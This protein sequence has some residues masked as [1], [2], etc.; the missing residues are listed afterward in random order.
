[1]DVR[2]TTIRVV[3]GAGADEPDGG[4]GLRI[5]APNRDPAGRAAGDLLALPLAEGV[6]TISGS[7]AVCTTRSAS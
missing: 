4:T 7:P 2:R 3:E 1:M 5:V 6:A